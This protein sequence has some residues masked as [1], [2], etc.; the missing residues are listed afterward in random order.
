MLPVGVDDH[1]RSG[2]RQAGGH[3]LPAGADLDQGQGP[4]GQFGEV[5]GA[6]FGLAGPGELEVVLQVPLHAADLLLDVLEVLALHQPRRPVLPRRLNQHL[7]RRERI[8]QLVG[9][10]G[11]HLGDAR[12]VLGHE[13]VAL[14]LPEFRLLAL[15]GQ[16]DHEGDVLQEVG[17]VDRE[18][19]RPVAVDAEHAP[20]PALLVDRH[21]HAGRHARL[22]QQVGPCVSAVAA[23]ALDDHRPGRPQR[24]LEAVGLDV[25][26]REVG[27]PLRP[28]EGGA[29]QERAPVG[30]QFEDQAMLHAECRRGAG[31]GLA[32]Q[33]GE[34]V[35]DQGPLR[36][37]DHHRLL[38]IA[39]RALLG[40]ELGGRQVADQPG[41]EPAI[42][43][44]HGGHG[45]GKRDLA[46][47]A[48]AAGDFGRPPDHARLAPLD[49]AAQ[50]GPAVADEVLGQKHLQIPAQDLVGRVP[51]DLLGRLVEA[52]DGPR[53]VDGHD[54]LH[55]RPHDQFGLRVFGGGRAPQGPNDGPPDQR[56]ADQCHQHRVEQGLEAKVGPARE[57][58]EDRRHHE[59]LDGEN[60]PQHGQQDPSRRNVEVRIA[61]GRQDALHRRGSASPAPPG[62]SGGSRCYH[63]SAQ[64]PL[65][66]STGSHLRGAADLGG[67]RPI[68]SATGSVVSGNRGGPAG[69]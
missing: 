36:L 24:G 31:G 27:E 39:G 14:P 46:A 69:T 5:G 50:P 8:A 21:S 12:H 23:E 7:D 58:R 3:A 6:A 22:A 16:G 15:H 43:E 40:R 28:S 49:D 55:G 53:L 19:P 57:H 1:R 2:R 32:E 10:A 13:H 26:G 67:V 9:H 62:S 60:H 54:A 35:A 48:A 41:E 51:E 29:Q 56:G 25:E 59:V 44:P 30:R 68:C 20:R 64:R 33:L 42:V 47:V 65:D 61:D 37:L 17:L 63:S 34:V 11:G 4:H 45:K 66:Y 52:A 38:R 18:R